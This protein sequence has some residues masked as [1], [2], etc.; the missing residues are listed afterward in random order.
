MEILKYFEEEK[1]G[2]LTFTLKDEDWDN[3]IS[4]LPKE[5]KLCYITDEDLQKRIENFSST[6]EKELSEILPDQGN[7]QSGDFGE[8][9][10]YFIFKER[11][12]NRNVDGPQKWKWK[13]EKNVAAPYTDVIL[14]SIQEDGKSSKDDLLISV[15]SKMKAVKNNTYNPIQAAIGGAEKDYVSRIANS[16]SWLRKKYKEESL[17]ENAPVEG[18]KKVVNSIERFIKSETYGE[19]DKKIKAIAFIDKALFEDEITKDISTPSQNVM[20]LSVFAVSIKDL[21]S[22]YTKV[23]EEISKL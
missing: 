14:F 5:Y 4:L 18:L 7:I 15:E 17:K 16:L 2:C 12:K 10:S 21:K 23:F 20:N 6:K 1:K 22:V 19:Y 9:L 8:I 13:Q 11:H 3:F